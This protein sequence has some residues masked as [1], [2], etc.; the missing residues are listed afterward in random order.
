MR[1]ADFFYEL[2]ESLI[3]QYPPPHR[4]DARLLCLDGNTGDLN[5]K[6]FTDLPG[7]LKPGDLL[8]FN[9]SKVIP[10]RLYGRRATGGRVELMIERI[11]TSHRV[12]VQM[13]V[14]KKPK[15]GQAIGLDGGG[16]ATLIERQ[17]DLW[18]LEF[19]TP[20]EAYLEQHG[21][22]PLPPYIARDDEPGDRQRYQT[23]YADRPGAVAAP[24]AGLHFDDAMLSTLRE[25]GIET[26]FV[27]LHVG[28]GTFQP[29]RSDDLAQHEM[30][31]ERMII[32]RNTCDAI[33]ATRR[34]GGRIIA[35]GTTTV[36]TLE[37]A[38]AKTG[39]PQ[40][41]DRLTNLFITPGFRF[42]V[43]DAMITNF[44]LPES[45]L[46]MLVSA[47]AGHRQ[48]LQAYAHAVHQCYR[49]FSYGD[50][51]FISRREQ[52]NAL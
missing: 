2:P 29:V 50:A 26:A 34:R 51:M 31:S 41:D 20:V 4:S 39:E 28:A 24:T 25:R 46:L 9:R 44:H 21:H 23:V 11:V 19:E 13:R 3:A 42:R 43:V 7:L 12:L 38:A 15:P 17:D 32:E 49:F 10:A 1:R 8:V 48:T 36:R 47:F 35:V 5:D 45:T 52:R 14:S 37:S 27:T 22:V 33:A 30:H 6:Q 40:P 18:L 16:Q